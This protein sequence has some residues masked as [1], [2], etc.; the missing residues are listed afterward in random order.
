LYDGFFSES[1]SVGNDGAIMVWEEV[2]QVMGILRL[3]EV[4][5]DQSSAR[6]QVRNE[7]FRDIFDGFK[8]V[9]T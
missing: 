4:H 8:V 3:D 7:R 1:S 5:H 6:L 9:I 2:V